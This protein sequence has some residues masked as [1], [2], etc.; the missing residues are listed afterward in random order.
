MPV[1][2]GASASREI[3]ELERRAGLDRVPIIA[4]TAMTSDDDRRECYDA[5]MDGL[6]SKPFTMDEL[7][8]AIQVATGSAGHH[9]MKDHPLYEFALT[10]GDMEP[11]LF[12]GVTMH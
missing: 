2:D 12:G 5:G 3:R 8:S 11:D 6:L 4:L 1:M 10:L 7:L 9:P